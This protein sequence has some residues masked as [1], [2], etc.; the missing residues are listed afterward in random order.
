MKAQF[1][2]IEI[3]AVCSGVWESLCVLLMSV[4]GFHSPTT[5]H[6]NLKTLSVAGELRSWLVNDSCVIGCQADKRPSGI[7]AILCPPSATKSISTKLTNIAMPDVSSGPST[8]GTSVYLHLAEVT[9]TS[10]VIMSMKY[11]PVM[12]F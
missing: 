2:I 5:H 12:A 10:V 4:Q 8:H 1:F 9:P 11:H 6:N 7:T 3:S